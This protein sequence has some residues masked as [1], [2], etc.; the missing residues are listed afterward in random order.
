MIGFGVLQILVGIEGQYL[1]QS[2]VSAVLAIASFTTGIVLGVFLLGIAVA[3]A[4]QLAALI[5]LVTGTL[6][7]SQIQF[8]LLSMLLDGPGD[9]PPRWSNDALLSAAFGRPAGDDSSYWVVPAW[10]WFALIG[11]TVTVATGWLAAWI[12]P[13]RTPSTD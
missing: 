6:V 3:R 13:R 7:V 5:G 1:D 9:A 11:S 12:F 4:G 8:D 10:P 2:V